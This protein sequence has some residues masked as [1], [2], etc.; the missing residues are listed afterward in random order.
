MPQLHSDLA[1]WF[2]QFIIGRVNRLVHKASVLVKRLSPQAAGRLDAYAENAMLRNERTDR[3]IGILL[4]LCALVLYW[5]TMPPTVLDGDS[6]EYQ[7]M[8]YILGVPHSPGYPLYIFLGKL[9]TILPIGDVAYRINLYSVVFAALAAPLVYWTARRLIPRRAPALL[10]TLVLI[11]TPSMWGSA[12]EAKSYALHLFLAVLTVFL[13]LR[14]H[15]EGRVR[16]FYAMAIVYGLALTN[17][18][19]IRFIAPALVL[20]LWM[21][22]A[23]LDR[24]ILLR[25]AILVALP[26]LMFAYV[27]IRAGQ[28]IALQD[29]EN[30]KLYTRPDAILKGTITEYYNH[31]PEGVFYFISA[32]DNLGKL[33]ADLKSPLDQ[34]GRVQLSTTMLWAQFGLA[35][36]VLLVAGAVESLRR[37]RRVWL[38]LGAVAA[39]NGIGAFILH[40]ISTV[41]Y[42]SVTYFVLALW[43]GFGI[44]VLMQWVE[45]VRRS[46]AASWVAA[47]STPRAVALVL[48]LLPLSAGAANFQSLDESNNYGPRDNAQ[49]VLHESLAPN[50]VVVAPWEVSQP[51]RYFQFVENQRP[52]LLVVHVPCDWPQFS[53]MLANA[54]ALNRPFYSVEFTPELKTDPGPRSVQAVPLPMLQAPHPRYAVSKGSIIPEVQVLGYDLDPDP[55]QP[56]KLTRVWIYYRATARM[57]PMYSA[58]LSVSDITGRLWGEYSR[59]PVSSCFP[60]YRWYELGEYYRDGWTIDLPADAPSG[61]YN[62]DLSWFVYDLESREPDYTSERVVSLG[63]LRVGDIAVPTEGRTPLARVG[64]AITLMGWESKPAGGTSSPIAVER[65]QTLDVDLF[66]R[67]ERAINQSYTVFVHLIDGSGHVFKDADSPP[68]RGLFPTDRWT[69]GETIRDRHTLTVPPDLAPGD[70]AIEIGMYQP[71]DGP[72]LPI[73]GSD[74]LVLTQVKVK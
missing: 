73:G 37:D 64:D 52:D 31:T 57:Y 62:L 22:R 8:A 17:H 6:G 2:A 24:V 32:L 69:V 30:L 26:L 38:F 7:Y 20:L 66:W 19:M 67:A 48:C 25:G 18:P 33:G 35:G 68:L 71:P 42:F 40:A 16:D 65:G 44:D 39:G 51:M 56:G 23:R 28:L 74:K 36:L 11:V 9:F 3:V 70:Y 43:I 13:A 34:I 53:T 29:P 4:G 21:N 27:P 12:I 41:F 60:T 49:T 59:F 58:M 5:R 54:H 72:R 14:W 63:S 50:A 1:I 10:A 55:P 47:F 45:S 15:Q 61:L 46:A